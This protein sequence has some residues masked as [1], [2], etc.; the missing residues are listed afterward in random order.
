MLHFSTL[1]YTLVHLVHFSTLFLLKFIICSSPSEGMREDENV[2]QE[3]DGDDKGDESRAR[4]RS[5]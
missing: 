5:F 2:E 3:K 4:V 1:W